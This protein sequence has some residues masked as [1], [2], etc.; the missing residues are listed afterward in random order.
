MRPAVDM[1]GEL[2]KRRKWRR[3]TDK[4][5]SCSSSI[6]LHFVRRLL[7]A[8]TALLTVGSTRFDT[9]V[10]SFLSDESLDALSQ[11]G[12]RTALAQVGASE[13]PVGW[14]EGSQGHGKGLEVEIIRFAADLEDRVGRAGLVVSHAGEQSST[15]L[16][17]SR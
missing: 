3:R 16:L 14:K 17:G 13:L 4:H 6:D 9:L 11:L 1:T 15:H 5:G 10:A 2:A 7:M 8:S 12:I